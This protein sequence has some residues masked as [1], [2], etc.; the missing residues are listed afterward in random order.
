M[1]NFY[2][3]ANKISYTFDEVNFLFENLSCVFSSLDRIGLIGD[4]GVGKTTL[5]NILS[6]EIAP[7]SG[8]VFQKGSL[9]LMSQEFDNYKTIKLFISALDV[10]Q[11]SKFYKNLELFNIDINKACFSEL[12]GG[13]RQKLF[14]AKDAKPI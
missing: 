11:Q 5:I 3:Q 7:T 1:S 10:K 9:S 12:S 6:Q 8:N 2:I 14:L 4:N 13:E